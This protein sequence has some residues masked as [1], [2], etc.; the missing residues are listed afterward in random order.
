MVWTQSN[1]EIKKEVVTSENVTTSGREQIPAPREVEQLAAKALTFLRVA[2]RTSLGVCG[3]AVRG[4]NTPPSCFEKLLPV[5]HKNIKKSRPCW[6][7]R[8]GSDLRERVQ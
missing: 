5:F 3:D 4:E 2:S 1:D 8:N 6:K 7:I